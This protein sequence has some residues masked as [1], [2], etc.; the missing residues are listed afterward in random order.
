MIRTNTALTS[1]HDPESIL[2][3][4][5]YELGRQPL[6]IAQPLAVLKQAGYAPL[7]LD[8]SVEPLEKIRVSSLQFI[9]ISVPMHTALTLGFQVAKTIRSLKPNVHLCFYGLYASL[10][11]QYLLDHV[12]DSII[13][14]EFE[15]SLV[16]LLNRLEQHNRHIDALSE[17]SSKSTPLSFLKGIPGV[18]IKNS[19]A[20]PLVHRQFGDPQLKNTS[21]SGRVPLPIPSRTT[22][23]SLDHYAKLDYQGSLQYVGNVEASRGCLHTCLHCPIVPVYHGRFLVIPE[24]IVMADIQQQVRLGASHITFG[25]PD[26][27]NGPGHSLKI[28]RQ[29]HTEFPQ[30]TFDFTTKIEH[31]LKR[32]DLIPEFAELG[33]LFVISAVESFSNI[34]LYHLEKGHR[35][36]DIFTTLQILDESG[37]TLRPSLVA[38]TPW[39]S[40]ED[41]IE[42]FDLVEFHDLIDAIDPVQF[43]VR[44]LIPP[45]SALLTPPATHPIPV[46]RFI[47]HLDQSKFQHLWSHPD[48]RMDVLHQRANEVVEEDS[49][50]GQSSENTFFRLK[51]LAYDTAGI[52]YGGRTT[53][54]SKPV[55]RTKPPRLTESWFCCAEPTKQQYKPLQILSPFKPQSN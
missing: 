48:P 30:L 44:L 42:M 29:M 6:G 40:L 13:G 15:T 50:K 18:S 14:G 53:M 12:A 20:P 9:G 35:R 25:D 28:L 52:P 26:F 39:T 47:T 43:T 45:G 27:L 16:T 33:C 22:L 41:Y 10:N 21:Q 7:S 34:V 11:A 1:L 51:K 19:L 49:Q 17:S 46:Q 23:P 31:I 54:A 4:S 37:I 32:R 2:L 5:C 55:E 8:L 36:E 3:I 38:F 24:Q